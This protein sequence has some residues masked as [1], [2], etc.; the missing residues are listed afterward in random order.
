M[1]PRAPTADSP[2]S[3][4]AVQKVEHGEA[5]RQF[6]LRIPIDHDFGVGP[7]TGPFGAVIGEESVETGRFRLHKPTTRAPRRD[8]NRRLRPSTQPS[9]RCLDLSVM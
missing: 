9:A 7:A 6:R 8:P 4:A 3:S 5:G 1:R 2:M